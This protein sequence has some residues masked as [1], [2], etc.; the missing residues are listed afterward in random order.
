MKKN[1]ILSVWGSCLLA[2]CTSSPQYNLS[3]TLT[4]VQSDTLLVRSFEIN[5]STERQ[6]VNDTAVPLKDGKFA[7]QLECSVLKQVVIMEKPSLTPDMQ[8]RIPAISMDAISFVLLPGK[9]AV[10]NGSLDGYTLAGDTFYDTYSQLLAK[11]N[12]YEHK[13]DSLRRVCREMELKGVAE[14]SLRQVYM[15]AE[16]WERAMIGISTDYIR[17]HPD[18][19]LSVFLLSQTPLKLEV[20]DSLLGMLSETV[21]TGVMQPL[22]QIIQMECEKGKARQQVMEKVKEGMPAPDFTL[23]DIQGNEFSLA[24]MKG[25]YVILDFWGSWCG[26]CIKGLPD[27]KE[28]Y[29]KHKNEVVFVGIDC[30]D[31][32]EKWKAAV[33]EHGIPWV[34]VRNTGQPDVAV[35][36]GVSGYPTK[37]VIDRQGNILK[38]MVGESEDF[39]N[40]LDEILK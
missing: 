39:Y 19:D 16:E 6:V 35:M 23:K 15:P 24:S 33:V 18:Q 1:L 17:K 11:Q 36:Y 21:R 9:E 31:T 40:Y 7:L 2:A 5:P 32:E 34:N 13:L 37:I 29:R 14:D 8:G 28:A 27:M 4:G 22:Y 12:V 30:N 20:V 38:R 25:K 3:G 10:V 26:W